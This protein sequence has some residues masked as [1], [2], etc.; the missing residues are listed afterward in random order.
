MQKF[1]K[2]HYRAN[3]KD[4]ISSLLPK[5][6]HP[7]YKLVKQPVQHRLGVNGIGIGIAVAVEA[8]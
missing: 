6:Q 8:L 7:K 4:K 2:S 5:F 3:T 1:K